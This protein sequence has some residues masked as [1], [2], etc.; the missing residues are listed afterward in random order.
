MAVATATINVDSY[1]S[2]YDNTQREQIVRGTIS[3][4][5]GG[6]YPP[7]GFPLSW[8]NIEG[9]KTIPP[10]A[11][12]PSSTGTIIPVDMEIHSVQ[13]PP[14]G[15][16]YLWD[17]VVGNLHIFETDN[18]AAGSNASGPL[19]EVGGAIDNKI[20]TDKIRFT[21]WFIRN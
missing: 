3:I 1:P 18:G 6:T 5:T 4:A 13:N 2:G 20:V 9:L 14:S 7:G 21:A 19:L 12:T 8:A 15:Y 11:S 10:G 16:I 17:S